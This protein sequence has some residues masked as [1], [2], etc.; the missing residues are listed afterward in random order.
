MNKLVEFLE[1]ERRRVKMGSESVCICIYI[2]G[3][4]DKGKE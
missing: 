3:D 4:E 2:N 1:I